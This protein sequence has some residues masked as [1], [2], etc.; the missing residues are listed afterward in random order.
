[1]SS[2]FYVLLPFRLVRF[3]KWIGRG[4]ENEA[5]KTTTKTHA[6]ISKYNDDEGNKKND[7]TLSSTKPNQ[8]EEN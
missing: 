3:G 5:D 1:M 6:H 7:E 4:I 8:T 2:R